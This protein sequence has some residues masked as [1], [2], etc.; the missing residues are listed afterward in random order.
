MSHCN[1][2]P[3]NKIQKYFWRKIILTQKTIL[4]ESF[5]MLFA[6]VPETVLQDTRS[7]IIVEFCKRE[8]IQPKPDLR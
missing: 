1:S 5:Q 2:Y 4:Y 6:F 3:L 7:I 8:I